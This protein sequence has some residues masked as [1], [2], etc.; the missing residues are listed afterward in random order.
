MPANTEFIIRIGGIRNPRFII[1]NSALA[2]SSKQQ[3]I[4]KTYDQNSVT[5]IDSTNLID[6]GKGAP[7]DI[8]VASPLDSFSI[9][10]FNDTNG[11]DTTFQVTW[12]TEI[13]TK[14]R[15]EL[16]IVFPIETKL[17]NKGYPMTGNRGLECEGINGIKKVKCE[18][19][20]NN[21]QLLHIILTQVS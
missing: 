21:D 13:E 18:K 4:I 8:S 19:D 14:D 15:D 17:I 5:L 10:T 11:A 20:K 7:I 3:F 16:E 12:F 6:Y 2:E 9:E 1:D